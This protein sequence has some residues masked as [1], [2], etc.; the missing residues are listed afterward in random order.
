MPLLAGIYAAALIDRVNLGAA[1]T[2]GMGVD[3]VSLNN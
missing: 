3:L 1:D 2:A